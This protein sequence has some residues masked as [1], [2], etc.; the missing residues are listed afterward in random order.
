MQMAGYDAQGRLLKRFHVTDLMT[1]DKIQTLKKMNVETYQ[2]GTNKVTGV[3][4]LEFKKPS[5]A[6]RRGL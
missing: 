2:T 1:V 5:K 3:T 6:V 4:Y